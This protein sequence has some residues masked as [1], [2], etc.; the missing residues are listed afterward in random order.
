MTNKKTLTDLYNELLAIEDV[1]KNPELVAFIEKR[2]ELIAKKNTKSDGTKKMTATQKANEDLKEAILD[3]AEA[4]T[5]YTVTDLIKSVPELAELTNQ[6]V[7]P[8]CNA[9]V[10]EGKMCKETVKGRTYFYVEC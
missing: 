1:K 3:Y 2:K 7:S 4:E 6:K 10:K 5:R 9:L 8:L